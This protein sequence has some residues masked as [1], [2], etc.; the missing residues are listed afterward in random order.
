VDSSKLAKQGK[1]VLA[2]L[3]IGRGI[4]EMV[5]PEQ[6]LKLWKGLS[7]TTDRWID[8]FLERP[9]LV[10]LIGCARITVGLALAS[11]Q[12]VDEFGEA[13]TGEPTT[14]ETLAA[15]QEELAGATGY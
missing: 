13:Q 10:R 12:R 6:H 2:M 14:A 15:E 3:L 5:E 9:N 7:Q 8:A 1:E 11:R 4:I